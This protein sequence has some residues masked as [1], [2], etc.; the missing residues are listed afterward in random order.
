MFSIASQAFHGIIIGS[1]TK[2][3]W[4]PVLQRFWNQVSALVSSDHHRS[5][6]P[7]IV[8]HR[9]LECSFLMMS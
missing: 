8:H 6:G 3:L 9:L 5:R 7:I 1:D 2:A 4:Q